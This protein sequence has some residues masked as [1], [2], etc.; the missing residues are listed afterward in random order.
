MFREVK[1]YGRDPTQVVRSRP[2]TFNK[3]K[4]WNRNAT[5]RELVFTCSWSD[6]FHEGA[7]EWRADAWAIIKATPNLTY[8]ILTKRPENILSRLPPDWGSGYPNVWLGVT[9]E[10]QKQAH[11]VQTLL[12][13]PARVRFVSAEPLLGPLDLTE[14]GGIH[15]VVA[16]G[17]SGGPDRRL[18]KPEWA[19]ALRD[20]CLEADVPF[21]LKQLG[22]SV[23]NKRGGEE[24]KLDGRLWQQMPVGVVISE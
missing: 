23:R 6:W 14:W 10:A 19:R 11:R 20:Q 15:W 13:I 1:R 3:P 16:G 12:K 4:K 5:G 24:A 17:E 7:D 21:F 18:M 2:A 9:V 22:G 8:Q